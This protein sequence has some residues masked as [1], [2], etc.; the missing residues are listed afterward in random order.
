MAKKVVWISSYIPRSCGIAYYS[1]HYINA[2]KDY[3]KKAGIDVSFKIIAHT[4]AKQADYPI[5]SQGDKTWHHKVLAVIKKEKPDIVH[6]QHEYGLYETHND[7][8][9]RVIELINMIK[10][11]GIP[12]VMTYHSVYKKLEKNFAEFMDKSLKELN[13][14]IVHEE[15]QKQGLKQNIGKI[16]KNV[17]VLPHGSRGDINPKIDKEEVRKVFGY[18]E[19]DLVVGIAG[20]ASDNKGFRT[21]IKQWPK[22]IKKIPNA[23]LSIEIKPHVAKE[24]RKYIEK[25]LEAIMKSP[26]TKKIEFTVED[27]GEMEFYRKLKSFDVLALPYKSES[28][29]GV[30]A[31]GFSVGTPAIVTDIEGLGAE[32]RN[33]QAGIAVKHRKYFYKAIIRLLKNKRLRDKFSKNA[34]NYVK[35]VNGWNIIAK[36]TFQIY[37]KFW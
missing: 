21:L 35:N 26:V 22:V 25:I 32:I 27:Y 30:L 7:K 37:D 8:N 11:Q 4:D 12:V 16:P 6:I 15:Y 2:L 29:S 14:G 17:Y 10:E 28:Q 31:H 9:R 23:K 34:L 3:A 24:T 20:I 36:K 13:A 19:K 5:I 33:S 1:N 18:G